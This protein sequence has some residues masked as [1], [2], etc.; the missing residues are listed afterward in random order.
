MPPMT[1]RPATIVSGSFAAILCV[2]GTYAIT[3][4]HAAAGPPVAAVGAS[5]STGGLSLI[6]P[7]GYVSSTQAFEVRLAFGDG[8]EPGSSALKVTLYQALTNRFTFDKTLSGTLVGTVV[9]SPAPVSVDSLPPDGANG[10]DLK[11]PVK[12][13]NSTTPGTG[14]FTLTLPCSCQG[15]YP[16]RI[17]LIGPGSS[18]AVAQLLTYLVYTAPHNAQPLRFALVVPVSTPVVVATQAGTAPPISPS[19]V[20]KL[21]SLVATLSQPR[22][23]PQSRVPLTLVPSPATVTSLEIADTTHSRQTLSSLSALASSAGRETLCGPYAPVDAG[24]LSAAGLGS[25]LQYQVHEG[26]AVLEALP[27]HLPCATATK[28]WL[29]GGTL[30][31]SALNTLGSLGYQDVVVPESAVQSY[32]C[33]TTCTQPLAL[34]DQRS[35]SLLAK[36]ADQ[37]LSAHLQPAQR[38]DPALAADQVLAELELIYNEYPADLRG[39]VAVAPTSWASDPAD[40]TFVNDLLAGLE[41][42]P[43]VSPVT[44]TDLFSQVPV[45]GSANTPPSQPSSRRPAANSAT[46]QMPAHAVRVAR[47]RVQEFTGAVSK[48]SLAGTREAQ[49]LDQLLLATESSTL[50]ARQ[51]N[52]GVSGTSAALDDQLRELS[53]STGPIR[54]TSNAAQIP[55]TIAKN[56]PYPVRG[57][58]SVTSDKLAFPPDSQSPGASCEQPTVKNSEGRSSYSSLCTIDHSTNTVNVDMRARASGD[59]SISVTLDSPS[60]PSALATGQDVNGSLVLAIGRVTVRSMSTSAVAI[61]LSILAALVLLTW[62]ARTVKR[63]RRARRDTSGHRGRHRARSRRP[64]HRRGTYSEA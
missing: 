14:P 27:V 8:L 36:T 34:G 7:P 19:S 62:W 42:N 16:L 38:A 26:Q 24:Q 17:Q 25:E 29:S 49:S 32:N 37:K 22:V 45:G 50:S 58:L 9:S 40:A 41:D 4:P 12:A 23:E 35:Q 13:G 61:A 39:V 15:V 64:A 48:L 47:A 59:F 46:S 21:D 11:I 18:S 53:V 2:L 56:L 51:R 20:S 55:I 43:M 28:I 6:A 57:V 52:A 3:A 54:L 31:Q 1:R 63:G 30:D 44:L 33:V 10:A 5:Q 60:G